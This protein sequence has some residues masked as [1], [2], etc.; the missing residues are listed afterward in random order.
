MP[1]CVTVST[2][3][4]HSLKYHIRH[5][6]VQGR[7]TVST[8]TIGQLYDPYQCDSTTSAGRISVQKVDRNEYTCSKV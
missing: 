3:T 7:C 8:D 2:R 6:G 1:S 5:I 4:Y